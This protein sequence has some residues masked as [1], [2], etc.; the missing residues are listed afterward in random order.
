MRVQIGRRKGEMSENESVDE[1]LE[2]E[3][4]FLAKNLVIFQKMDKE[5]ALRPIWWRG[6]SLPKNHKD[7]DE[8]GL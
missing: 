4:S 5:E 6:K 7:E 1:E 2:V 3:T 8:D